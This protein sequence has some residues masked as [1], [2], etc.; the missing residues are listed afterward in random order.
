M[1]EYVSDYFNV[2]LVVLFVVLLGHCELI[3][4]AFFNDLEQGGE[5]FYPQSSDVHSQV[6]QG[7]TK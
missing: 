3:S 4:S 1:L 5:V 7:S 2:L 6:S